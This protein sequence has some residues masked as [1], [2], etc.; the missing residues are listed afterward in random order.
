MILGDGV[1]DN[2]YRWTYDILL[3]KGGNISVGFG[4]MELPSEESGRDFGFA[5]ALKGS[6]DAEAFYASDWA[7]SATVNPN[8]SLQ[9]DE[10]N[11]DGKILSFTYPLACVPPTGVTAQLETTQNLSTS[12][13]GNI[14]SC[15]TAIT[16]ASWCLYPRKAR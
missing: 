8:T 11:P 9:V 5:F 10:Q 15:W 7:G 14:L 1:T 16:M 4:S 12:F 2:Q 13:S 6:A 3:A